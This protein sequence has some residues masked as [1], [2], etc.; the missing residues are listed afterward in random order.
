M[1]TKIF[2]TTA[3]CE[4]LVTTEWLAELKM[5]NYYYSLARIYEYFLFVAYFSSSFLSVLE[6]D[7]CHEGNESNPSS[8][9][10][11]R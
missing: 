3:G 1:E 9:L 2:L 10:I 8:N 5:L 6:I 4:E 11:S 7:N